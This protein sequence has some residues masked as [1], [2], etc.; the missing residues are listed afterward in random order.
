[1]SFVKQDIKL[2]DYIPLPTTEPLSNLEIS[3][4]SCRSVVPLTLGTQKEH[5]MK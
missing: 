4:E 5:Q 2:E 3:T 1:M